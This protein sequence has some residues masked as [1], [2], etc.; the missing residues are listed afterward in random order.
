MLFDFRFRHLA[1]LVRVHLAEL[2]VHVGDEFRPWKRVR[3]GRRAL[4]LA[5]RSRGNEHRRNYSCGDENWIRQL[6][7]PNDRGLD[8][9]GWNSRAWRTP[10]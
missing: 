4:A 1:I 8:A 7:L 9:S 6:S 5:D 10:I 3:R 2:C